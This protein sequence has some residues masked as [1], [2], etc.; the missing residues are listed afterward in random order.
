MVSVGLVQIPQD[1][2]G[3]LSASGQGQVAHQ[4]APDH[5]GVI[6]VIGA[7][8]GV[9]AVGKDRVGT[10]AHHFRYGGRGAGE[11]IRC[12][13]VKRGKTGRDILEIGKPDIHKPLQGSDCLNLFIA[14]GIVD[15]GNRKPFCLG[16]PK[17]G[18][19][20]RDEVLRSHEIDVVGTLCLQLKAYFCKPLRSEGDPAGDGRS[21]RILPGA[22]NLPVLTVDASQTAAGEKHG[23][24][25]FFARDDRF[26]CIIE[27]RSGGAE[28]SALSAEAGLSVKTVD[29]AAAGTESTVRQKL[30]GGP[31]VKV[32]RDV[33]IIRIERGAAGRNS[34]RIHEF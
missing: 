10:L 13:G 1:R 12:P 32:I 17:G 14:A 3:V 24:A 7:V 9:A 29:M 26:L 23:A 15:N 27:R 6:G 20:Q 22:R 33:I 25:S 19:D 18:N 5:K 4:D 16:P 2:P 21:T 34:N 30:F 28:H 8:D 31:D 11:I